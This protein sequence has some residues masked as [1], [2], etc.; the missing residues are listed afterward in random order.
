MNYLQAKRSDLPLA[1]VVNRPGAEEPHV[2]KMG[3]S[4]G[5]SAG[6]SDQHL[7]RDELRRFWGEFFA[8][9]HGS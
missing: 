2:L 3:I 7:D 5:H 9:K 1:V 8:A 6:A 4:T